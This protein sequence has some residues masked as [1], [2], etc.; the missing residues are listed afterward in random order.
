M[1]SPW[2]LVSRAVHTGDGN[3]REAGSWGR[4]GTRAPLP[5]FTMSKATSCRLWHLP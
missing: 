2:F 1:K 5:S 4:V 3:L